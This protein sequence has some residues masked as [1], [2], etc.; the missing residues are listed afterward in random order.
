MKQG[1]EASLELMGIKMPHARNEEIY[2]QDEPAGYVYKV[3]KGA[4]RTHTLLDDGRRQIG[5]F[6]LPGDIFGL[7]LGASHRFSAEAISDTVVLAIKRSTLTAL[8]QS[9]AV[10][11]REL[12]LMTARELDHVQDQMI[13]L[14]RSSAKERVA[15]FLIEMADRSKDRNEIDLPMSRQDIADYLGL[16]IETVSRTFSSMERKAL[17]ELPTSRKVRLRNRTALRCRH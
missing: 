14:G 11:A 7:E 10:V 6:Y 2:G 12:W 16:T 4:V 3:V 13:L 17:I 5:A 8:A 1:F 15:S 9:D